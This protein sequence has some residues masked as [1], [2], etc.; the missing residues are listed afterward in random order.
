MS[1]R[2]E[3]MPNR[4]FTSRRRGLSLA[5]GPRPTQ[6]IGTMT[7]REI[8]NRYVAALQAGDEQTIRDSFAEDATWTLRAGDLP[9]SGTWHGRNAIIDDFLAG[10]L[11]HYEPGSI[12]L[13]VT[14]MIADGDEVAL[15]WTTR[16]RTRDGQPYENDCIGVFTVKDGK[17][18]AVREYM[19][20]LY[21]AELVYGGTARA[22]A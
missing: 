11:G 5:S 4:S 21:A 7:S 10:A 22:R 12:T 6:K 1:P 15:Q 17:I 18:Q 9:L 20:T 3:E 19:D 13:E 16:A 14:G 8:L 2:V